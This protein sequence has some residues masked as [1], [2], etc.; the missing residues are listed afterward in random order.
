MKS[1]EN[2]HPQTDSGNQAHLLWVTALQSEANPLIDHFQLKVLGSRAYRV[3]Q[4]DNV[5]LIVCGIGEVAAASA[6]SYALG[7]L[8][9]SCVAINI[10]IAGSD[11]SI[12]RIYHASSIAKQSIEKQS[13]NPQGIYYPHLPFKS[14]I[15][16]LATITVDKPCTNYKPDCCFE[17]EAYGFCYAARQFIPGEQIH[18]LK[19]ISDNPAAPASN[20]NTS[21]KNSLSLI[22][23]D[24]R[25]LLVDNIASINSFADQLLQSCR[26]TMSASAQ[27]DQL[28]K[29]SDEFITFVETRSNSKL[30]FTASQKQQLGKLI[31]RHQ[32]LGKELPQNLQTKRAAE[33]IS[34]LETAI[35]NQLPAYNIG[36]KTGLPDSAT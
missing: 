4:S 16:G 32:V 19:I 24:I 18:C 35:N 8:P 1:A 14:D 3:Y 33:I 26:A 25:Q 6:T 17:M 23:A 27:P 2:K 36:K 7:F 22:K 28:T 20:T 31:R 12:G 29:A 10:G 15:P 30:H 11:N 13:D 5:T 21:D 9:R 34:D